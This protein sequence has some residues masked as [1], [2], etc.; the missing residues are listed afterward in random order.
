MRGSKKNKRH[1]VSCARAFTEKI[2]AAL[3][4][5]GAPP[6]IAVPL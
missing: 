1:C 5:L 3:F 6:S 2:L 4:T